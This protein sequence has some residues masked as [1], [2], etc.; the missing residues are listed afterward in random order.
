MDPPASATFG[1]AHVLLFRTP[2]GAQVFAQGGSVICLALGG[3][4][5]HRPRRSGRSRVP[6]LRE[7]PRAGPPPLPGGPWIPGTSRRTGHPFGTSRRDAASGCSRFR[8]RGPGLDL[9]DPTGHIQASGDTRGRKQ[10]R[11]HAG[12]RDT[13]DA[14]KF[15]RFAALRGRL[16]AYPAARDRRI[17][18]GWDS[19]VRRCSPPSSGCSRPTSSGSGTSSMRGPT[20]PRLDHASSRVTFASRGRGSAFKFR[21]KGGERARRRRL[22]SPARAHRTAVPGPARSRAL[23]VRRRRRER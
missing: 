12:W 7:R 8:P 9:S 21:G 3:L 14:T 23:P 18:V 13:R 5:D 10:Y 4:S 19:P 22:R 20:R 16:P 15:A 6:P 11:Y 1:S 17:S 2:D